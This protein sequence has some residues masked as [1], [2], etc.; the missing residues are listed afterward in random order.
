M[1]AIFTWAVTGMSCYPTDA[2]QTDVVFNV[3]WNC[4]AVQGEYQSSFALSTNVTYTAGSPYTPYADLAES[5]VLGWVFAAGI[6]QAQIEAALQDQ[7]DAQV[8]PPV[9]QPPLPWA[10]A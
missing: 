9:V 8:T 6:S 4:T 7:I 3:A 5:Q 1:T 10:T 2:G